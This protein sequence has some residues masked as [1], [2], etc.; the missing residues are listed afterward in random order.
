M[1]D[2]EYER[3]KAVDDKLGDPD[4]RQ[5]KVGP[6]DADDTVPPEPPLWERI[7]ETF[8]HN[9]MVF[10]RRGGPT[11]RCIVP[12]KFAEY[13]LAWMDGGG[14][15]HRHPRPFQVYDLAAWDQATRALEVYCHAK[16]R[17]VIP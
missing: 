5:V 7:P 1:S 14:H 8:R 15:I 16:L 9:G 17:G 13:P 12:A 3:F 4:R 11:F 2:W 6:V 10:D